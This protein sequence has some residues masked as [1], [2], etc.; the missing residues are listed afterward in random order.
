MYADRKYSNMLFFVAFQT[1]R[2]MCRGNSNTKVDQ[3]R[4]KQQSSRY[5]TTQNKNPFCIIIIISLVL[6]SDW[7]GHNISVRDARRPKKQFRIEHINK[8][9]GVFSVRQELTINKQ[10]SIDHITTQHTQLPAFWKVKLRLGSVR[11]KEKL[12]ANA[13]E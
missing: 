5:T 4:S 9:D 13:L 11:Q 6:V 12:I 2:Q 7:V 10:F 3:N 8:T 1:G